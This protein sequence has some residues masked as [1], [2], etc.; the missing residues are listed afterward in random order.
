MKNFADLQTNIN[1]ASG[2][3]VKITPWYRGLGRRDSIHLL[4][5][6]ME[7]EDATKY[8]FYGQEL[9]PEDEKLRGDLVDFCRFFE[10]VIGDYKQIVMFQD[11]AEDFIPRLDNL[12]TLAAYILAPLST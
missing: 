1:V 4:W 6:M 12:R 9:A 2:G 3:R 10:P 11:R 5:R 8:V 7:E